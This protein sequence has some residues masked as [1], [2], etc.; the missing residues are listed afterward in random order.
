MK[1]DID[2]EQK[3]LSL[4]KRYFPG[5]SKNLFSELAAHNNCNPG[6]SSISSISEFKFKT[7][8]LPLSRTRFRLYLHK[9]KY[10]TTQLKNLKVIMVVNST[11]VKY[12]KYGVW[13]Y[14]E[15]TAQYIPG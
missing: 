4:N 7:S 6:S 15:H 2:G 13:S 3:C 10:M 12:V 1:K 11:M 9:Q 8:Q 14:T 5:I